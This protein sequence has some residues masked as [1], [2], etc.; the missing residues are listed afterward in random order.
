MGGFA[1]TIILGLEL[2]YLLIVITFQREPDALGY[3]MYIAFVCTGAEGICHNFIDGLLAVMVFYRVISMYLYL[4][5]L[6][7][8]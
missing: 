5:V 6:I 8:L 4:R 3:L 1:L 2:F 7:L